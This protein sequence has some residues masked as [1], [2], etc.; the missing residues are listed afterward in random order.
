[1]TDKQKTRDV[2]IKNVSEEDHLR[3]KSRLALMGTNVSEWMRDKIKVFLN[4]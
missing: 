4:S 3:L 1:M 2:V